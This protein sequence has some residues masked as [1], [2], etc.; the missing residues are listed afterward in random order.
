MSELPKYTQDG[1]VVTLAFKQ[2]LRL[3]VLTPTIVQVFVDRGDQG[4]SYA[5]EGTKAQTTPYTFQDAG[6][7]YELA[8]SALIVRVDADKHVDVTDA[9][10]HPLITDYRG[11]RVI[12]D[13]GVDK[14]HQR[15]VEAEGHTVQKAT[16][17]SDTG[18]YEVVKSL[19]PDEHFYG[20]GDKTGYL[21]KRGFEYDNWNADN[22]EPQL[23]ILPN[24][25][26]S[27]PV[28]LGLKNGHPYGMFFDNPYKSHFD[29]GK[30]SAHYYFYSAVDGNVNYYVLGGNS[31]KD[32]VANYTYLT[33]R[34]PLPQE[35]TLGYQ[36]SRWG[37][38]ASQQEVQEIADNLKK[39]DL[40]CDAIHFDVDYMDGYRVF[41]WDK[42][43]FDG[44]PK[45]FVAKLKKR[46]IKV[47]P[48]IDPGV[49]QDPDYSV[50]AEG[51]KKG[52]FVKTPDG[53][54]YI[55]KVWPGNS[56]FPDFGRPEVRQWWSKNG[57]FLTDMGAA[58]IWIDM[59]EPASFEGEIPQ[60]VVFSDQDRP[61]THK[62]MH[63]VYGHNMA[64]ATYDGLKAQ[65][66][67]RPYVI[68]RA[69]YAGTQKYAT[70][71]TG[72]NRSMWPHIQ[73][74][75]PQLC[76]LG[77]SGFSFIGTD[78]GGFASDTNPELL[79]RWIEA[80]IFSPLLRNHAA[81]GTRRQEPWVFGE[82]TLSIYR[83]YLKLRYH[84][85]PYL[86][87]LFHQE[88]QT[89][90]P[91]MRPLV[92]ND[93]TD[94]RV[95]NLNDEFMV[96]NDLLVAPVLHPATTKRLVYLPAG[97]WIDFWNGQ[98]VAGHQDVIADA[99]L[100]KLPL[101]V[102]ANTLLPWGPTV[103]HVADQPLTAMTFKLYGDHGSTQHYQDDGQ[104]FKY[105]QGEYNLYDV[106]V[107]GQRVSVQLTHH[108]YAPVYH[109]ITVEL[110]DRQVTLVYDAASETYQAK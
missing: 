62:K 41:T 58:G 91:I 96:G 75:V 59:N 74:M 70:V 30:E 108:G 1:Q 4:A 15:L 79:T 81:M 78:I 92:L 66:G 24:L 40:P 84:L 64:K 77:M 110:A 60:D 39:Y 103:D 33:G 21:D 35:W 95:R 99:P 54:V 93:D 26:K 61:S 10:G 94:E 67:K 72:D 83:K 80:A 106:R 101:Y 68:T 13:K 63:N 89:G 42:Q 88:T 5:I 3:T 100:D 90:L 98:E 45:G 46:G 22:T 56:A 25:Y 8:T 65:Q 28:M 105:Q 69:A 53:K 104:D 55:N 32:V 18:Y 107:A 37:Y 16:V 87:D 7:H 102:R 29:M 2:P 73:M 50:Y 31:L 109:Q 85:I 97:D 12:L 71:W 51:V 27:I 20:L 14:V 48:I 19:A 38:S 34:T 11:D 47:I 23:E 52:Y 76:N 6:D 82:P 43:K 57:Q 9:A 86:Y 44:D 49:K 36:Q 17:K